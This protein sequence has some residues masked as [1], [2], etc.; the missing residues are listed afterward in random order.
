MKNY[1]LDIQKEIRDRSEEDWRFGSDGRIMKG[2]GNGR[3]DAGGIADD[4]AGVVTACG[5]WSRRIVNGI[6]QRTTI[7]INHC[8][9]SFI[10]KLREY[11]PI[12]E[13]QRGIDDYMD[14]VTR[15]FINEIEKILN[16]CYKNGLLS[17]STIAFF[18]KYNYF[19]DGKIVLSNR[20]PAKMS[21]TGKSGNSLKA[22][23]QWIENNG[24]YPRSLLSEEK[25]MTF[26]Q[27]Y[28]FEMKKDWVDIGEKSKS[29]IKINYGIVFKDNFPPYFGNFKWKIF[30][31]YIDVVD[32]DFVKHLA[33][34]YIFFSYGYKLIINDLKAETIETYEITTEQIMRALLKR[35]DLRKEF[36]ASNKF[37]SINNPDYTIYDWAKK[38]GK[39][40]MP[41]IFNNPI[42]KTFLYDVVWKDIILEWI[43][44]LFRTK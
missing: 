25:K 24:I 21:G 43:K 1:G 37:I 11:Y 19:I 9:I 27:Y 17:E 28:G 5:A 39:D 15:G 12:G 26:N 18:N 16:Y 44:G 35:E 33:E 29:H 7:G 20:I 10:E 22:V 23:I 8:I 41:E 31:N 14:C 34:D 36:P 4:V 32:G 42:H 3:E 38:H 6:Y 30:D 2:V 40:E 13:V